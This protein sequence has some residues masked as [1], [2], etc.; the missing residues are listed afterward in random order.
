MGGLITTCMS[1]DTQGRRK[2]SYSTGLPHCPYSRDRP[3]LLGPPDVKYTY[4]H[5]AY[6]WFFGPRV[7]PR[8]LPPIYCRQPGHLVLFHFFVGHTVPKAHLVS[9]QS[10]TPVE[11]RALGKRAEPQW[12]LCL[13]RE[14]A[15]F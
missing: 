11:P 9:A 12:Q 3:P 15:S 14:A 4:L 6:V 13:L 8:D 1:R 5:K 2:G 7:G 10:R